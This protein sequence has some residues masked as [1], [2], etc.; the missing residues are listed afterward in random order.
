MQ[1]Q[2]QP[3]VRIQ[4][5]DQTPLLEHTL[6]NLKKYVAIFSDEGFPMYKKSKGNIRET[7]IKKDF[8]N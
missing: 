1:L 8:K 7:K 5:C 3:Y 2:L 6:M 4:S